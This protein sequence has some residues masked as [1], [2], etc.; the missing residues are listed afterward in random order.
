M[1]RRT[2]PPCDLGRPKVSHSIEIECDVSGY[3]FSREA[4]RLRPA[5]YNTF[6]RVHGGPHHTWSGSTVE[7]YNQAVSSAVLK[8]YWPALL[9]LPELAWLTVRGY[10]MDHYFA[11][12]GY[13][14]LCVVTI[15]DRNAAMLYKLT[16]GKPKLRCWL[17]D[18]EV[19]ISPI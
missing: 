7:D 6:R 8:P 18:G 17:R 15:R 9:A 19:T 12:C 4:K 11:P 5:I 2:D 10:E 1:R 14:H 13:Y 3:A 16:W